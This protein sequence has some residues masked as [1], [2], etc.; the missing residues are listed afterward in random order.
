MNNLNTYTDIT[1][2]NKEIEL[3]IN[4]IAVLKQTI[5]TQAQ[6][7]DNFKNLVDV[8]KQNNQTL[9]NINSILI[10]KSLSKFLESR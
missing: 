5:N 4:R 10:D 3:L 9:K 2:A 6:R 8:L 1:L 7:I